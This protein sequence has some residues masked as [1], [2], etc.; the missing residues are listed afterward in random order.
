[1]SC[2][3]ELIAYSQQFNILSETGVRILLTVFIDKKQNSE[4]MKRRSRK[5]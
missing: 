3:W 4:K 5:L 2:I 1:M